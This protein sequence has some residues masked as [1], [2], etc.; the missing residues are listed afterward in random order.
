MRVLTGYRI[1]GGLC[2]DKGVFELLLWKLM[3]TGYFPPDGLKYYL[4]SKNK[5]QLF[6]FKYNYKISPVIDQK[7]TFWQVS[8]SVLNAIPQRFFLLMLLDYSQ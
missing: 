5:E 1:D 6:T 4:S 2:G 8:H 3:L 7:T